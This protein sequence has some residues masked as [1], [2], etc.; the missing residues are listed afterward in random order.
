MRRRRVA[1]SRPGIAGIRA[2]INS[3]AHRVRSRFERA[4]LSALAGGKRKVRSVMTFVFALFGLA[5]LIA[6]ASVFRSLKQAVPSVQTLRYWTADANR[7]VRARFTTEEVCREELPA[8]PPRLRSVDPAHS[9][10]G[11][12]KR[13][14][15]LRPLTD[16][17]A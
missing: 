16:V 10:T 11:L 9:R 3:V 1:L 17:A 13:L 5:G 15:A 7:P 4:R 8:L 6:A 12:P 14:K 2:V